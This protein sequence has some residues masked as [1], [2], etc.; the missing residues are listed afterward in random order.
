M[1]DLCVLELCTASP[2]PLC[3]VPEYKDTRWHPKM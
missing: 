2:L 3:T 1:V